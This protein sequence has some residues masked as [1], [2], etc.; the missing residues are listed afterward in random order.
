MVASLGIRLN[1][2]AW[3]SF[4]SGHTLCARTGTCN[5]TRLQQNGKAQQNLLLQSHSRRCWQS[6]HLSP[7]QA[8]RWVLQIAGQAHSCH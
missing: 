5:Q 7:H 4:M 3:Y 6:A 1:K 2:Q 8:K